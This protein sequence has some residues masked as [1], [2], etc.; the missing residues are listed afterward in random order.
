MIPARRLHE[1]RAQHRLHHDLLEQAPVCALPITR[2]DKLNNLIPSL[3]LAFSLLAHTAIAHAGES[4]TSI[5]TNAQGAAD[6]A[7]LVIE[8]EVTMLFSPDDRS[9]P[10]EV[11]I[12][13]PHALLE[14]EPF[15]PRATMSLPVDSC[16]PNSQQALSKKTLD[17]ITG[18]RMRFYLT[19]LTNAR[20]FRLFFMQPLDEAAPA[21]SKVKEGFATKAHAHPSERPMPDGW[22]RA[23]STD[24]KFTV[25]MPGV[26]EDVTKAGPGQPGFMLRGRD[27]NGSVF[28]AVFERSGPESEMSGTFDDAYEKRGATISTFKGAAAV[29]TKGVLPGPNGEMTSYGRWFRVP[30][31]TFM[32]GVVTSKEHEAATL[33][34]KERFFNSL[35]F[36]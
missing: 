12:E 10:L 23:H 6:R 21:F 31:G 19:R 2:G 34:V 17:R 14:L 11:V 13:K 22:Y 29:T 27:Q 16:F 8:A 25:D 7:D 33:K 4:C 26:F 24:G 18:K 20:G 3:C 36:E 15:K 30:G 5:V 9:R 28:M 1:L 35:S 32:L